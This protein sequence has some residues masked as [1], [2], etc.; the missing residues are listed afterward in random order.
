[1]DSSQD[2]NDGGAW[3]GATQ[4]DE[5][6]A[7]IRLCDQLRRIADRR[8]AEKCD[9]ERR[10]LSAWRA[11]V[12]AVGQVKAGK[13]TFLGALIGQ[14][15]LLPADVNPWTSVITNMNFGHPDAPGGSSIFHFFDE[16]D[17]GRIIDGDPKTREMAED[18]LPGFDAE[19]LRHQVVDMRDRARKRLGDFYDILLGKTHKY[20]RVDRNILDRYVCAGRATDGIKDDGRYSDIT[21]RAELYFPAGK[22]AAPSVVTDTPGVNDPFLVRDEFTCRSLKNSDT[23]LL[24]LSVHQALTSVDLS[25][26][27]LIGSDPDKKIIV[28]INR[29]DELED[30]ATTAPRIHK[31]VVD[32]LAEAGLGSNCDVVIGSAHWASMVAEWTENDDDEIANAEAIT[33]SPEFV[34]FLNE[35]H[36]TMPDDTRARLQ[37]ASGLDATERLLDNAMENAAGAQFVRERKAALHGLATAIKSELNTRR[38]ELADFKPHASG[39]TTLSPGAFDAIRSRSIAAR[40]V[41]H[42]VSATLEQYRRAL[43]EQLNEGWAGARRE[44][45]LVCRAHVEMQAS[46]LA[47]V[48]EAP[49]LPSEGFEFETDDLREQ[50]EERAVEI[51]RASRERVDGMI[52]KAVDDIRRLTEPLVGDIGLTVGIENLPNNSIVPMVAT[53]RQTLSVDLVSPRGWAFWTKKQR[54]SDEAAEILRR[55]VRVEFFPLL[56]AICQLSQDAL[57]ER[58]EEAFQRLDTLATPVV[59]SIVARAE[60]DERGADRSTVSEVK[61]TFSARVEQELQ[62]TERLIEEMAGLESALGITSASAPRQQFV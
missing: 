31:D 5:I 11:R 1:M 2:H 6:S 52:Q 60:A 62:E 30:F 18:L 35:Q 15:N 20:D 3:I 21:E 38:S 12:A 7:L 51:H 26:I 42:D 58:A 16:K 13:S 49:T 10:K 33:Q 46:R 41:V 29:I 34:K 47:K 48:F 22:F 28:F 4:K 14:P 23:F 37:L 25:L 55:L 24:M 32:E 57:S 50:L 56:D 36:G 61:N 59:Q 40:G 9:E 17:W 27:R 8:F 45:D 19:V 43:D 54:T 53:S 39:S 44:L